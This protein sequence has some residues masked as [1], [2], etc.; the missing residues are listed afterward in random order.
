MKKIIM[1]CNKNYIILHC[2]ANESHVGGAICILQSRQPKRLHCDLGAHALVAAGHSC[3][4][5]ILHRFLV[6]QSAPFEFTS[7]IQ[8]DSARP[9]TSLQSQIWKVFLNLDR[10]QK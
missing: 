3:A 9:K 1:P 10:L 6:V 4:P 5:E 7:P 8:I 2:L